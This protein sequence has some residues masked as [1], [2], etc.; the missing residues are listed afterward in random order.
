MLKVLF[1]TN[2]STLYGANRSLLKMMI[3]LKE[4]FE[5]CP[6]LLITGDLGKMGE[7]CSKYGI[8]VLNIDFRNRTVNVETPNKSIRKLSR[9]IMLH[10]DGAKV[11]RFLKKQNVGFDLVHSNSSIIDVGY[12]VA[13]AFGVPHVWHVREFLKDDYNEEIVYSRKRELKIYKDTDCV[14]AIS[15]A[16]FGHINSV[17]RGINCRVIYNGV[18][19][20]DEYNKDYSSNIINLCMVGVVKENKNQFDAVKAVAELKKRNIDN[21]HLHFFGNF[22]HDYYES[23]IGFANENGIADR[24]TFHGYCTDVDSELKKM[25]IGI[26]ASLREAFG[27]VTVEY[28]SNYMAVAGSDSG[29]NRELIDSDDIYSLHDINA[30][31]DILERYITNIDILKET[32]L[33]NRKKSMEFGALS[34]AEAVY[35]V[36]E[37]I[38][39][40]ADNNRG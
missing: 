24:V 9:K 1:I 36:Y 26:M 39:N 16:V 21:I 3:L 23:M 28:M 33:K 35:G 2:Y 18:N 32:G 29:A 30:L 15:R 10:Y 12:Y 4:N 25:H 27:R 31:A 5:V 13:K 17:G 11:C 40:N 37:D 38:L 7:E 8:E 19:I 20:C 14:I 6:K 22:N 34:N